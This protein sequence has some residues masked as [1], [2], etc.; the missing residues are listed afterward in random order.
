MTIKALTGV[1]R[2][3]HAVPPTCLENW[4]IALGQEVPVLAA[5]ANHSN[6]ILTKRDSK[7]HFRILHRS[8][9]TRNLAPSPQVTDEADPNDEHLACRLC[10]TEL[11]RFSHVA[12]CYVT[13]S[14]FAPLVALANLFTSVTLDEALINIGAVSTRLTLPPGLAVL[15][16]VLWKFFLIDFTRVDTDKL[17]FKPER[18]WRAAVQRVDRKFRARH[19]FL[20]QQAKDAVNLG[21]SPPPLTSEVHA[22]PL[23]VYASTESFE[24]T[25]SPHPEWLRVVTEVS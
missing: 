22:L 13:R 14:V 24:V 6:P 16:T 15:H 2:N 1:H 20:T 12:K 17:K 23:A 4:P 9:K 8:L 21:R 11:E 3:N 25:Y 10:L 7:S 19:T 18:P 5:F